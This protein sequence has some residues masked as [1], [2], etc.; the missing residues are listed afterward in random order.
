MVLEFKGVL[1]QRR[2]VCSVFLEDHS[3]GGEP[4]DSSSSD[5]SLFKVLLNFATK[6][7]YVPRVT[8]LAASTA[9]S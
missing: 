3:L 6:F 7:E 8:V 5:I 2:G 9:F 1:I 4:S